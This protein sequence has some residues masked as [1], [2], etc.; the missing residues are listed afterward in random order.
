M[1]SDFFGGADLIDDLEKLQSKQ[2]EDALH[3]KMVQGQYTT[4][5]R[6]VYYSRRYV[7]WSVYCNKG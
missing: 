3:N 1:H 2:T 4:D 7:L 5:I 6:S